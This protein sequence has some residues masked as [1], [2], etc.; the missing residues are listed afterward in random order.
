MPPCPTVLPA[1]EYERREDPV[2]VLAYQFGAGLCDLIT[3]TNGTLLA[4]LAAGGVEHQVWLKF[5]LKWYLALMVLGASVTFVAIAIGRSPSD[6]LPDHP[7]AKARP[8]HGHHSNRRAHSTE[9]V[10]QGDR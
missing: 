8:P 7:Q 4:V 5:A 1:G 6:R 10:W 3:P 2:T 9:P